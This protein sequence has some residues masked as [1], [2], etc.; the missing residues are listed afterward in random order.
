MLTRLLLLISGVLATIGEGIRIAHTRA[1]ACALKL[2]PFAF[3]RLLQRVSIARTKFQLAVVMTVSAILGLYENYVTSVVMAPNPPLFY[4]T[5]PDLLA[6][7]H[8]IL[9]FESRIG[10][11]AGR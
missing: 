11:A 10:T 4:E 1:P 9:Y 5:A 3:I 2:E 7:V 6:N 8:K